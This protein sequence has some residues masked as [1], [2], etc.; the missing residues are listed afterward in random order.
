MDVGTHV[1]ASFA[2]TRA[3]FPRAPRSVLP[4]ALAVGVI[5]DLD[6]IST[7]F[8]PTAYLNWHRTYTHS[9][10]AAILLA[11]LLALSYRFFAPQDLRSRFSSITIFALTLLAH[12][13]HLLLYPSHPHAALFFCPFRT[14]RL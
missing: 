12:C 13:F 1:L 8:G 10:L 14:A 3:A 4:I 6:E 7:V 11:V 9:L 5:A 2:L